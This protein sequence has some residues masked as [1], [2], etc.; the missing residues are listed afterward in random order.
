M[1]KN[2]LQRFAELEGMQRVFQPASAYADR[3][4]PLKGK[5]H[6]EV[7]GNNHPIVLELGCG[8]G[9]YTIGLSKLFPEKNF[10]GVDR[11][12][13]RIWQGGQNHQ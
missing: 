12:G 5:W 6:S 9:E 11:K 4:Y 10:I 7:F 8:K 3:D 2:K 1:A 13:A